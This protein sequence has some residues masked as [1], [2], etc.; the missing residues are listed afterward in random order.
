M[1]HPHKDKV[2]EVIEDESRAG[3]AFDEETLAVLYKL[4][5][6]DLFRLQRAFRQSFQCG[7]RH[8]R[9]EA[10]SES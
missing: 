6:A 9:S 4:S 5:V 10:D 7:R 2:L 1:A 3:E 8:E